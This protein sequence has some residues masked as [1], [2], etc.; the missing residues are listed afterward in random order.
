MNN[1]AELFGYNYLK[2]FI[3][4]IHVHVHACMHST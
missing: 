4:S 1:R 2:S 3:K